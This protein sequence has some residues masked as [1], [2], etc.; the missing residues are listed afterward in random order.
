MGKTFLRLAG[1][2]S[3]L[4]AVMQC[5]VPLFG[6]KG[7]RFFG[8]GDRVAQ[9]VEGGALWPVGLTLCVGAIFAVFAFYAL[10]AASERLRPPLL[11]TGLL[12]V[13]LIFMLRGLSVVP[14]GMAW[15][16][17]PE[18]I[19]GRFVIFSFVALAMGALYMIGVIMAWQ[20][21]APRRPQP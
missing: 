8:A 6:A 12:I 18:M 1:I 14:Q 4:L 3:A 16:R 21:L 10:A 19:P 7:Y 13:G 9:A 20:D 15:F 2:M 5:A 17:N 11:R